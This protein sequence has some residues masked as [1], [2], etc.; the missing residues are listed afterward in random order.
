MN[1]MILMI[2]VAAVSRGWEVVG[3]TWKSAWDT[4]AANTTELDSTE[5]PWTIWG[6][7][8]LGPFLQKMAAMVVLGSR[9]I[10]LAWTAESGSTYTMEANR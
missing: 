2:H 7:R 1:L 5:E 9:Q 4:K 8:A 6:R 10:Y 3:E